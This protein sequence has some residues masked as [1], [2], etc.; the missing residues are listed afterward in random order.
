MRY[1]F[2]LPLYIYGLF[3]LS[4][5]N[6]AEKEKTIEV[7][8]VTIQSKNLDSEHLYV[9]DIQAIRNVELRSKISGFLDV[10]YVDEGQNVKKGQVLFKIGDNEYKAEV[11]KARAVLNIAKAEA[12]TN[13]LEYDRVKLMVEKNVISQTE[14]ELALSRVNAAKAK[15][16]EAESALQN[17]QHRLSYTTICSPFD[18]IVDRIPLK[19]GS[20]ISEG[21]LITSLSD[22]S[23]MYA[24]F[25]I[26]ENE[27]L[28]YNREM[29]KD[30]L[31]EKRIVSLILSDGQEYDY[32][33]KIETIVS[34]F[35]ASTGSIS[36]RA[37]FPNPKHLLKHKATGKVKLTANL[38]Q[39]IFIPQKAAFEIQDKNYVFIVNDSNI[40]KMKNFIPAG[41]IGQ[42]YIIKSGLSKG[43][44]IVYEGIQNIREGIKVI[45]IL[46]SQD[47]LSKI[48]AF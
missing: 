41:R 15:I 33:G 29:T 12:R 10:I 19:T 31:T 47:S 44:R 48:V 20:L 36:F 18:G 1:K 4:C 37:I 40:V 21:S 11:A 22:I 16:E 3:I 43:D 28:A 45:P 7:P 42:Y 2:I 38:E 13:E 46:L 14:Q 25:N 8:I 35:D 27:Y 39:A 23:S 26:S 5:K 30:T 34:E 32:K 9:S 24:Y 17:S 6:T